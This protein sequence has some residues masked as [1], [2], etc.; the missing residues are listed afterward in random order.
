M[1][2]F[3]K[4]PF[5]KGVYKKIMELSESSVTEGYKGFQVETL[6]LGEKIIF[7]PD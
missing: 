2:E 6:P 5:Y 4:N 3:F 1:E 7:I